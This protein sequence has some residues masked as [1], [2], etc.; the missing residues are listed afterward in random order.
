MFDNGDANQRPVYNPEVEKATF[1]TDAN[2][3]AQGAATKVINKGYRQD[4]Y[5]KK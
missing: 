2:W 3:S 4:P 1:G 5:K